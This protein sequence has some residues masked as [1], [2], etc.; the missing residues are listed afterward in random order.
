MK[1]DAFADEFRRQDIALDELPEDEDAEGRDDQR[2][3]RPELHDGD[4][5]GQDEPGERP[6]IGDEAQEAGGHAD[7]RA[8][9]EPKHRQRHGVEGAEDHADQ[10]LTANETGDRL[11]DIAGDHPDGVAVAHGNPGIDRSH[12]PVPVDQHVEGDDGRHHQ[13]GEDA[14]ER[15]PARPQPLQK[16]AH[17]GHALGDEIA[18]RGLHVRQGL[19]AAEPF[20]QRPA[21]LHGELLQPGDIAGKPLDEFAQLLSQQRHDHHQGDDEDQHEEDQDD[22]AGAE[23]PE[24]DALKPVGQ[25]V[26]HI[27]EREACDERQQ[28]APE[29]GEHKHRDGKR[30]DPENHLPLQASSTSILQHCSK[31]PPCTAARPEIGTRARDGQ[32]GPAIAPP[33][34]GV[35]AHLPQWHQRL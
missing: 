33:G 23:P 21:L 18:H 5:H 1:P 28:D 17:P 7:H 16:R 13:K 30:H 4:A 34:S 8:E 3:V 35:A 32:G 14:E 12:H 10:G 15:L 20:D 22:Q 27:G 9:I 25:R 24:P 2:P 19:G 29:N 11:V 26:H 6:D 31:A